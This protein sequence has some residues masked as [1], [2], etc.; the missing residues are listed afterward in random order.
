[1]WRVWSVV[2]TV[3]IS[4]GVRCRR[5]LSVGYGVYVWQV[6]RVVGVGVR[7]AMA[8]CRRVWVRCYGVYVCVCGYGVQALGV[9]VGCT[10]VWC[11]LCVRCVYRSMT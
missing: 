7:C 5:G 3:C 1:M 4:Y 9:R 2:C 10:C 11:T 6:W 8:L